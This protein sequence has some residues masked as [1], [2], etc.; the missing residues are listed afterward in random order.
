MEN[1][2]QYLMEKYPNLHPKDEEGNTL[3]PV[4]GAGCPEAWEDVVDCL[5]DMINRYVSHKI[6]GTRKEDGTFEVVYPPKVTIDQI[7]S[8]FNSLRFY[9]S[10]GDKVVSGMVRMAENLCDKI[11]QKELTV[12]KS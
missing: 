8:K 1:F 2:E 9:Y 5:C 11:S 6:P 7:K 12:V 3:P 4:C 10:G